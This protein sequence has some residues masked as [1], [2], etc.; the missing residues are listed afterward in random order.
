MKRVIPLA[1]KK[2]LALETYRPLRRERTE[3]HPLRQLFWECTLRCNVHCRHCGSDCKSAPATPDM[4]L[5]DFLKVLDGIATHINPRGVFVIISGGEPTVR[6]DLEECGREISRRGYPWGMVCNG[7]Y[8]TRE[9][10]HELIRSG[11]RSISISLD[12]MEDVHNWMRRH[13]DSFDR[14]IN[15]IR[16]IIAIPELTFDVITSVT[17]RSL[18]QLPAMKE[19]LVGLGVK[20]WR[21]TTIFPV[22]RAAEE[23]EFRLSGQELRQVL[24]FIRDTR[25]EGLIHTSYGCEGFLGNYE[26]EVRDI[27]FTCDAGITV[28]SVLIDGSI[29]ACGSIRSNYHQGNIYQDDFWEVWQNKFQPYRNRTWMKKDECARCKYFRYCKGN[30]MHLRDNDGKLLVCHLNRIQEG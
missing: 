25:K 10:L 28:G 15:A 8:I 3:K 4:P 30:G 14:A 13:P 18:P 24:D 5:P 26:G 16:E 22:G 23:P 6:Q 1:F 29:S 21:V 27:P 9:R 20:H 19:L 12:G 2:W 17:R 7:L 11:M